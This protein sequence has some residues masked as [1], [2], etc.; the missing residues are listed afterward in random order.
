MK[1]NEA[2]LREAL[3]SARRAIGDHIAPDHCYSTGPLTGNAYHDLVECPECS[4]IARYD[5]IKQ[6]ASIEQAPDAEQGAELSQEVKDHCWKSYKLG[7]ISADH[8]QRQVFEEVL[9]GLANWVIK[10]RVAEQGV[11]MARQVPVAWNEALRVSELPAV[12][13]A[14]ENFSLDSTED[15]AVCL[16]QA[17]LKIC[18]P[19]PPT[20][21]NELDPL[22]ELV[23]IAQEH[24]MGYGPNACKTCGK[25][26]PTTNES[27]RG[28]DSAKDGQEVAWGWLDNGK[29]T[30]ATDHPRIW[31]KQEFIDKFTDI[32]ALAPIGI[33]DSK[34]RPISTAPRDS[35]RIIVAR[36]DVYGEWKTHEAWWRLP[37]ESAP[38]KQCSWCHDGDIT[39]LDESIHGIGASFWTPLPAAPNDSEGEK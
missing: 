34:W 35:S 6:T 19:L 13:Q 16:V 10:N 23:D 29:W 26:Q 27:A 33:N 5:A 39:L 30:V 7:N 12:H 18:Q 15:N 17:I 32:T 1:N 37:Y 9:Q 36:K 22:Q 24:D 20:A 2:I 38:D 31:Y 25:S 28:L 21:I 4:F 11:G 3:E 8:T 14:L